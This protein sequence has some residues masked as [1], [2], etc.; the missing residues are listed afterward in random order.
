MANY[1]ISQV[2]VNYKIVFYKLKEVFNYEM[3]Y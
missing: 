1:L 3:Q 2:K